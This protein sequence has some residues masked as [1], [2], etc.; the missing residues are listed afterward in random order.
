MAVVNV[1]LKSKRIVIAA[2][3]S[4]EEHPALKGAQGSQ[5]SAVTLSV[6][7]QSRETQGLATNLCLGRRSLIP[8]R[9]SFWWI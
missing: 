8:G 6:R 4:R 1:Y 2:E 7:T 9:I 3:D 5:Y